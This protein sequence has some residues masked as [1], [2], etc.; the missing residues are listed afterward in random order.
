MTILNLPEN[1][2]E[3]FGWGE[4]VMLNRNRGLDLYVE[5]GGRDREVP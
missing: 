2:C 4:L 3:W 1:T 5:F